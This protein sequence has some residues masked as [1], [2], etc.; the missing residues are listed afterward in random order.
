MTSA[1]YP[2]R[3]L[4]GIVSSMTKRQQAPSPVIAL[5]AAR[6]RS[7]PTAHGSC[8]IGGRSIGVIGSAHQ[9]LCA[10]LFEGGQSLGDRPLDAVVP[11]EQQTNG[12]EELVETQRLG[13]RTDPVSHRLRLAQRPTDE[14]DA[15]ASGG[16]LSHH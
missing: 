3:A 4:A 6:K 8:E 15:A 10:E 13:Q 14:A 1:A 16:A 7:C 2:E 5:A 11:S 9:Q 12:V